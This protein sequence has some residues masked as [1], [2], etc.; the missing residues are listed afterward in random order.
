[1]EPD[2]LAGLHAENAMTPE[3]MQWK[4]DRLEKNRL[5][6]IICSH[7]FGPIDGWGIQECLGCGR[8]RK[9]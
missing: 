7:L 8:R 6:D 1:M 3:E 4:T 9:I 5:L 2:S